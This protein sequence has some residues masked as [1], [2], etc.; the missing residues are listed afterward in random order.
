MPTQSN[1]TFLLASDDPKSEPTK[2]PQK[3]PA[4]K[5]LDWLQ[6]WGKPTVT[7][8]DIRIYGPKSIRKQKST[9]GTAAETLV[10]TKWLTPIKPHPP[11]THAWKITHKPT[12]YPPVA[13]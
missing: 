13:S 1:E 6:R 10:K 5:L 11:G 7:M 3:D 12:I 8:R 9:I 2:Q 4:Q